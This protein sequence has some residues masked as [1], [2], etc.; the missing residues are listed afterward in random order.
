[1]RNENTSVDKG[2]M[3]KI[4]RRSFMFGASWNYE[5][6]QNLCFLYTIMPVLKKVYKNDKEEMSIAMKRHL[7]FYNT[8][9]TFN[10]F[11]MGVTMAL[12]ESEGNS[13]DRSISGLKTGLMGPLAGLG[14]SMIGLTLIPIIFSIGASYS[15]DG[16]LFGVFLALALFNL[17]N[18]T[19]KYSLLKL[20][21][22]KG[23]EYL[24]KPETKANL[25]KITNT[26]VALGVMLVGGLV[27]QW[28]GVKLALSYTQGDLV[29]QLQDMIDG[30][31]P[32]I[33]PLLL[34]L[35]MYKLI[36]K[37]KNPVLLILGLIVL[38]I[39]LVA[40]GILG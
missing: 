38:S 15:K 14:D 18:I 21:Y 32:G 12:E 7:E 30:I 23:A 10:P 22:T 2:M 13:A 24:S 5:R 27:P 29:I 16:S 4:F 11:I 37:G 40:L 25:D 20:G 9:Y 1:M 28:V 8:H 33:L 35:G 39:P 3:N 26:A 31:I 36:K 17:I 34:T 6:M 19:I